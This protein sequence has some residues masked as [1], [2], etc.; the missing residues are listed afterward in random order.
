MIINR[1]ITYH[2]SED[3][4]DRACYIMTTVG[5]GNIVKE[6]KSVDEFGRIAY[7]CL[8]DTG[9]MLIYN[10]DRTKIVTLYIATNNQ[11]AWMYEGCT[12]SW[13]LKVVKKNKHHI[14]GQN[15]AK[16]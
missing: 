2:I 16:F 15:N 10:A 1:N 13:M 14:V 12:P 6:R 7:K 3:R 11:V 8:T 5:M 4:L 9:V